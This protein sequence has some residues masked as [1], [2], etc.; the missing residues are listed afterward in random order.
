MSIEHKENQEKSYE[1]ASRQESFSDIQKKVQQ[2]I[3]ATTKEFIDQDNQIQEIVNSANL[4]NPEIAQQIEK[5]LR[6]TEKIGELHTEAQTLEKETLR[7]ILQQNLDRAEKNLV[8]LESNKE[9]SRSYQIKVDLAELEIIKA[10]GKLSLLDQDGGI[11]KIISE[12][13]NINEIQDKEYIR[14]EFEEIKNRIM[15]GWEI[16]NER[17]NHYGIDLSTCNLYEYSMDEEE[18]RIYS[19][20]TSLVESTGLDK[21]FRL[22]EKKDSPYSEFMLSSLDEFKDPFIKKEV[23]STAIGNKNADV[24]DLVDVYN[25]QIVLL[26]ETKDIFVSLKERIKKEKQIAMQDFSAEE[27]ISTWEQD[28][29]ISL[30]NTEIALHMEKIK[31]YIEQ[32]DREHRYEEILGIKHRLD[33][34]G[35]ASGYKIGETETLMPVW[36]R[37]IIYL[38]KRLIDPVL[39]KTMTKDEFRLYFIDGGFI[40]PISLIPDS[41]SDQEKEECVRGYL[42]KNSLSAELIFEYAQFLGVSV[43]SIVESRQKLIKTVLL[44]GD[45]YITPNE[46]KEIF[47]LLSPEECT[48][49]IFNEKETRV[50]LDLLNIDGTEEKTK[51][52]L[53]YNHDLSYLVLFHKDVQVKEPFLSIALQHIR[54][55]E[56][57]VQ[58]SSYSDAEHL[59]SLP[60]A[61]EKVQ[62]AFQMFLEKG[63]YDVSKNLI[64]NPRFSFL[65][66]GY[67]ENVSDKDILF[68]KLIDASRR[69]AKEDQEQQIKE[70]RLKNI[71]ESF[72]ITNSPEKLPAPILATLEKFE[73]QYGE[74]GKYLIA[75]A[76]AAYGTENPDSFARHMH[77]FEKILNQYNPEAIP[78]GCKVSM[79]IEYE[80]T[81]EIA[82]EYREESFLGYKKDIELVSESA[83]IGTGKDA[84]HEIAL[85]PNYNPYMLMAEVKLLQEAGFFDLNFKQYKDAPR[86]YH[87]SLVGDN[88]LHVNENMHFLNNLL[89]MT[90]L[91]GVTAGKEIKNTKN[92][93]SKSFENFTDYFQSGER[94]EIKGM[95]TDSVEQFEKAIM[96][97]HYAGI[98]IQLCDKYLG[99]ET[100]LFSETGNNPQAFE[101]MLLATGSLLQPFVSD[102]E[103]DIVY[104]WTKLKRN[105]MDAVGRHNNSFIDSEFHGY[106]LTPEGEYIDTAEHI[107]VVRNKKL[108]EGRD[109]ESDEFKQSIMISNDVLFSSQSSDFVNALTAVNS[110]FLKPPQGHENSPV[111]A[112]SVL[113]TKK[114]PGYGGVMENR[115]EDSI[116][117]TQKELGDGY[118]YVQG[119]SEE[120]IIHKSQIILNEFYNHMQELLQSKGRDRERDRRSQEWLEYNA[121]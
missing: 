73:N 109:I 65:R 32:L 48:R 3:H 96:T 50:C 16:I 116:F 30:N 53:V 110:I 89:T 26:D 55:D 17:L 118:Y 74:K 99:R 33:F 14:K 121:K 31:Q 28:P 59:M 80:V 112:K 114:Y 49:M 58:V 19:E 102:Q 88:G 67:S 43:V 44:S 70:T 24:C 22:L 111:N 84:I 75:L 85:K 92:I 56:F 101:K 46:K 40:T 2:E 107:D 20:I 8:E 39:Q 81:K 29:D 7:T 93:H 108:V 35:P 23:F 105:I 100:V 5:E 68:E 15:S 104:A 25:S 71:Q 62:N 87:L 86:G 98:A 115:V 91:T 78:D 63:D 90:Q 77:S 52:S 36:M 21:D 72:W 54:D 9:D 12:K 106:I 120:M 103:R 6:V 57:A 119:A 113:D 11:S 94:C 61:K 27:I 47:Q 38:N 97:S 10:K 37:P 64:S 34:L 95:A 66:D 60:G 1:F 82:N 45:S 4:Q 69:Y 18:L 117:D 42:E 76:I 79:G 13:E 83:H 41:F 51:K